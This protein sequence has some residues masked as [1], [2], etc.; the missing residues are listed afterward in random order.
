MMTRSVRLDHPLQKLEPT[1][2]LQCQSVDCSAVGP[3]SLERINTI[4]T[5]A[6]RRKKCPANVRRGQ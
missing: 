5:A 4:A 2:L 6:L 3:H 1:V